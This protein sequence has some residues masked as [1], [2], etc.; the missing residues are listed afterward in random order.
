MPKLTP[1]DREQF[2]A[3]LHIGVLAVE[4][5][6]RAPLSVPLFYGYEPGGDV[7]L[8]TQAGSLKERLIRAA[9]RFSLTAQNE[10]PPY[11]YVTVEGDVTSIASSTLDE[12]IPIAVRY[13]GEDEGP[14]QARRNHTP[15]SVLIRMTP[16]RWIGME[17]SEDA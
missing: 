6:G 16:Q 8:S 14:Q 17:F 15:S 5:A 4:R 3:E 13:L 10:E 11:K 1:A 2:L 7:V 9:G 12:V